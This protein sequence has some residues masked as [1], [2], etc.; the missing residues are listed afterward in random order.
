MSAVTFNGNALG[1]ELTLE[2]LILDVH[3]GR[4]LGGWGVW[5][6]DLSAVGLMWLTVSG[7]LAWR[8]RQRLFDDK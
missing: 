3:A 2:R 8:A 1:G 5:L 7:Y 4:A 6:V